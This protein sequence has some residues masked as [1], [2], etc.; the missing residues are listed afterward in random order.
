[1]ANCS[2]LELLWEPEAYSAGI[3]TDKRELIGRTL[4]NSSG[5][6][7]QCREGHY[8]SEKPLS[9]VFH[10]TD[11]R[12]GQMRPNLSYQVVPD[13]LC[14]LTV[15]GIVW[16]GLWRALVGGEGEGGLASVPWARTPHDPWLFPCLAAQLLLLLHTHRN[17][18]ER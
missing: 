12:P 2:K 7:Q 3:A 5:G 16:T 9:L 15:P 8:S 4:E 13:G 11:T 1:M 10:L 6:V 18:T 14:Q 17:L